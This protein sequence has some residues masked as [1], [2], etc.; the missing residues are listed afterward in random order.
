[1]T[2]PTKGHKGEDNG[3]TNIHREEDDFPIEPFKEEIKPFQENN[4]FLDNAYLSKDDIL[5]LG[6]EPH[7]EIPNREN[8]YEKLPHK[9]IPQVS[10]SDDF[11]I[12]PT[13]SSPAAIQPTLRPR[14]NATIGI[15]HALGQ[16]MTTIA[17]YCIKIHQ[18]YK[19]TFHKFLMASYIIILS[20]VFFFN[21]QYFLLRQS[22]R[23]SSVFSSPL[24]FAISSCL[25]FLLK[26]LWSNGYLLSF[27]I[28]HQPQWYE[29]YNT[30]RAD[31]EL[32]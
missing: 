6:G 20:L 18:I 5:V 30:L 29:C 1:M 17:S 24:N 15:D 2:N 13:P 27:N 22:Q 31:T 26:Y 8:S 3:P 11:P 10:S 23:F 21:H 4:L 16:G 28:L 9:D 25:A 12:S 19:G 7:K 14:V 32:L